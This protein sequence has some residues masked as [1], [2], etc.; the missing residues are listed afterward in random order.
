MVSSKSSVTRTA[1]HH[2]LLKGV[3]MAR[4]FKHPPG[5]NHRR[6]DLKKAEPAE[7]EVSKLVFDPP[8]QYRA[9]GTNRYEA[10]RATI[11]FAGRPEEASTSRQFA[12][13]FELVGFFQKPSTP[14]SS[15]FYKP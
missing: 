8:L 10:T 4:G 9:Q 13:D 12:N 2:R 6:L 5:H 7:E 11:D 1:F 3:H 14:H 15:N